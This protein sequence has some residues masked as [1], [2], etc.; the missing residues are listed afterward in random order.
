MSFARLLLLFS[1]VEERSD[2]PYNFYFLESQ[3][4]SGSS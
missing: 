3:R 2:D 4:R 1:V